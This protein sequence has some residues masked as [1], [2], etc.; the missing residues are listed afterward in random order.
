MARFIQKIILSSWKP[1]FKYITT[2][3]VLQDNK[4]TFNKILSQSLSNRDTNSFIEYML[5][6]INKAIDNLIKDARNHL[7]HSNQQ[8]K[9]L[10]N[11]I[12]SYPQSSAQLMAKLNLKSRNGFRL[13]Y[14]IPA[15]EMNLIEMT[16]PDKPT[17]KNQMYYKK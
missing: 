11:V 13:N 16:L 4:K 12:E 5:G 3:D 2:E 9:A 17:S 7:T 6:I 1:I 8:V 10:L 15:L 14:I